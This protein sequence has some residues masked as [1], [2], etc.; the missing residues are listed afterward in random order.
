LQSLIAKYDLED[1]YNADET[2]LYWKLEPNKSLAR[3]SVTG[4]KKSKDRITIMLAC[5]ATGTHKLPAVFIYKFKNSRFIR[6]I[7]KKTLPVLYY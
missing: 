7:D 1:V 3:N 5:N 4:T 2:A 6:N